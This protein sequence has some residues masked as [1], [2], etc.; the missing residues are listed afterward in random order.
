MCPSDPHREQEGSQPS[1]GRTSG[2]TVKMN[3]ALNFKGD[4]FV[5]ARISLD[6]SV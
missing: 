4:S 3:E 6:K 2:F 5:D 1:G